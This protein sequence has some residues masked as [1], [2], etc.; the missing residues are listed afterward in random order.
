MLFKKI[1]RVEAIMFLFFLALMLQAVIERQVR[2]QMD[3]ENIETVPI[4]PEHRRASHPTTTKIFDRFADVSTYQLKEGEVVVKRF[5]DELDPTQKEL[6][7]LL[8]MTESDYW[9]W[10]I[11]S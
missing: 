3:I 11:A 6:L 9:H 4:Y 1:E 8:Q 10:Q 2:Q 7:R 5:K